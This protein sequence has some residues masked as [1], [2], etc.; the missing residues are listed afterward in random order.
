MDVK[1]EKL[2]EIRRAV[3]EQEVDYYGVIKMVEAL[4]A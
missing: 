1:K 2:L 3:E 4:I